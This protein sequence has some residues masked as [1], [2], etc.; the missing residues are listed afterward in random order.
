[1]NGWAMGWMWVWPVLVLAGLMAI[2]AA[3]LLW[4]RGQGSAPVDSMSGARRIL[5]ERFARGEIDED[6]YR[7]RRAELS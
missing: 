5:D 6:E 4:S 3:T 1:M 2:V 7:R